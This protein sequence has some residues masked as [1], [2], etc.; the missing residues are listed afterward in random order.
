MLRHTV[1]LSHCQFLRHHDP[2]SVGQSLSCG[3]ATLA[4]P[5][6]IWT[7]FFFLLSVILWRLSLR[8]VNNSNVPA[9]SPDRVFLLATVAM[10]FFC[11]YTA[12]RAPLPLWLCNAPLDETHVELCCASAV[13]MLRYAMSLL[14]ALRPD[15]CTYLVNTL[16]HW[17]QMHCNSCLR[18]LQ[19]LSHG[20]HGSR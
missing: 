16:H 13:A 11:E 17:L 9:R 10:I 14:P 12:M 7:P 19:M 4:G 2:L 18:L 1:T 20:P 5:P 3:R 15:V 6:K 8:D